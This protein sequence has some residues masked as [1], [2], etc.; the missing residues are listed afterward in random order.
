AADG[1]AVLAWSLALGLLATAGWLLGI[2]STRVNMRLTDRAAVDIEA[3][4]VRMHTTVTGIEHHE[5]PIYADR[6]SVLRDHASALS[7]LYQMLFAAVGAVLRL[8]IA[9][10]LLLSVR[11]LLVLVGLF[12]IPPVLVSSWRAGVEKKAEEAG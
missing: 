2:I 9:L 10:G 11:P 5:R 3:H 1:A 4:M 12:A 7:Q 6:L 8:A